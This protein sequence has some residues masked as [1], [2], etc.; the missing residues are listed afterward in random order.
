[1]NILKEERQLVGTWTTTE[2]SYALKRGYRIEK[3]LEVYHYANSSKDIFSEYINMWLKFKQQSDGWPAWV[4]SEE[5]KKKYIEN[6]LKNEGVELSANDIEKN[7][8]LRFI[9][10]LFL[11]TLWGKLAQRPN[12]KQTTVCTEYHEY[13]RLACDESKLIKGELMINDNCLLVNWENV[14]EE[15]CNNQ[16]TSLAIASFVTS[17][18]RIELM[19]V[20]DEIE[21]IPGRILY[22]DTDSVIFKYK[23]GQP[24]PK[25]DDYL[26]CLADEISKD[27]GENAVC[28]K[29]CSLGP[30]VYAMEIWPENSTTPVVPIK[31]KGITLT[32]KAMDILKMESMTKLAEEYIENNGDVKKSSNIKIPQMEIR[33]NNMQV[34]KTRYFEKTFRA[35]SNKRRIKGNDTL[36]YGFVDKTEEDFIDLICN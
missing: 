11:N 7:P 26:G 25:T 9:A 3:I 15:D 4:N 5:D 6:F 17:Y 19:K 35:M 16:N 20:I 8:A 18:A 12:L 27:Y 10:K 33:P 36:P 21:K 32:D 2:L 31:V 30:K 14:D 13:W 28:T 1:M 22:M 23:E 34:I 24:K 29:F